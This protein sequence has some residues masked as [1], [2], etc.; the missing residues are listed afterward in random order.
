MHDIPDA[1][2]LERFAGSE[3]EEAFAEL[4]RRYIPLVYSAAFRHTANPQNAQEITQAVFIILARKSAS[5]G[6]RSV[7]SGWLYHT[8]RLTAANFQRAE[9]RRIHREQE[10]FMQT[11][12]QESAPDA[13][14]RE[15]AP[16]LDEA[17]SRLGTTDRDAV[18]LRYFENKSLAEVGT[19]LGVEE[20]AAQKRV[21][22]ALEKLRKIFSKR[23]VALTATVIAGAVSANSVQAAPVGLAV[24]VA[25]AAAKGA[26]L[27]GSTLT[28][29]KGALKLMAW[30]KARTA[31]VIGAGMLLVG[32][33]VATGSKWLQRAGDGIQFEAEGTIT[34]TMAQGASNSYTDTKRFIVARDGD[35]WKIRTIDV[36]EEGTGYL[37]PQSES[38]DLYYEMGF[39]GKNIFTLE[40]QDEKKVLPKVSAEVL[41]SGPYTLALGRVE[42]AVSP[43]CLDRYQLFPVWLAFCSAPY[44]AGL[45]DDKAVS[46]MFATRDFLTE[47]ITRMQLP[48]KWKLNDGSFIK[49]VSWFSDGTFE[50]R[51]PDGKFNT[52]K[53]ATPYDT[54]FV[55]AHFVNHSWTNWNG[56]TLPTSFKL[57]GYRPTFTSRTVA[58]FDV[59]YTIT[60]MVDQIR[61]KDK[62]IPTP[63]LTTKTLITDSRIM[64]GNRPTSYTSTN[65]WDYRTAIR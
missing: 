58:N 45:R 37:I 27:G 41:R 44:F 30:A 28:L 8:T 22:R 55:Q 42:Q 46:A 18:V 26:A 56:I 54:P 29:V 11:T 59:A 5:L 31:V 39:D 24:T 14:W 2:L 21:T 52:L 19:A 23:G 38:I 7:L 63:K 36:K 48:A 13:A 15:V 10:A 6:R 60:G 35:V 53:Y 20:R 49:D 40:Q 3:S 16:L 25:A 62:L 34:Y 32:G 61:K 43:P 57:V 12:L 50:A 33:T 4:V 1:G 9:F 65:H 47:S 64:R 51:L 17:M